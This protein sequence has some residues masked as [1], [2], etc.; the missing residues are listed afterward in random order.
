MNCD[1]R[2]ANDVDKKF[3]LPI[4]KTIYWKGNKNRHKSNYNDD[5]EYNSSKTKR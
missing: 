4:A 3:K 5:N 1:N 2:S